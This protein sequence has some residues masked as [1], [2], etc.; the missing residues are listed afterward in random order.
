MNDNQELPTSVLY[1]ISWIFSAYFLFS[2][3]S[4]VDLTLP[5]PAIYYLF[6]IFGI[7]LAFLPFMNKIKIGNLLE[8]ERQIK[9]TKNEVKEF[10]EEVRQIMSIIST[11]VN[12]IG[13]LSNT[14][15]IQVPGRDE[16][17][18]AKEGLNRSSDGSTLQKS[19]EIKNELFLEDEDTIMALARTRIRLEYLLRTILGKSTRIEEVPDNVKYLSFGQLYRRFLKEYPMHNDLE[20]SFNYVGQICNAAIHA[21]KVS[22]NQALEALDLGAKLIAIIDTNFG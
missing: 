8:L 4:K 5:V 16:L 11:N 3:L 7:A 12:T 17:L 14:I 19:E 13:N 6:L 21:Q 18:E 20:S 1:A 10:K 15:N 22:K 2:F 9:E